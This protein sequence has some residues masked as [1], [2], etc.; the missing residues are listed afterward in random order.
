MRAWLGDDPLLKAAFDAFARFGYRRTTMSD[1][2]E[3][4]GMSRPAV[5]LRVANKE[6]LL[7]QVATAVLDASLD[8]AAA[9]AYSGAALELRVDGVLQ[10]KLLMT[11]ELAAVSPHAVELLDA[12]HRLSAEESVRYRRSLETLLS[13]LFR[14]AGAPARRC[15]DLAAVLVSAVDGLEQDLSDP[16]RTQELLTELVRTTVAGLSPG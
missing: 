11:V 10:A 9:A 13:G 7:R 1:V 12:Y 14:T 5:Y 15:A 2:A 4:A 8:R 3:A 6:E 16:P